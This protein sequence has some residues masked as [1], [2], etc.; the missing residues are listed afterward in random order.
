MLIMKSYMS[1]DGEKFEHDGFS[2]AEIKALFSVYLIPVLKYA[3]LRGCNYQF[4]KMSFCC[5]VSK[6][7]AP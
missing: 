6:R 4:D 1:G 7:N 5:F 2:K 3:I